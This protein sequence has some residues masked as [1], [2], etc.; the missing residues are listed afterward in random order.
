MAYADGFISFRS[1]PTSQAVFIHHLS[2]LAVQES[3]VVP[4]SVNL[5][6]RS[7]DTLCV[8]ASPSKVLNLMK[9]AEAL[10]RTNRFVAGSAVVAEYRRRLATAADREKELQAYLKQICD[11]VGEQSYDNLYDQ[12]KARTEQAAPEAKPPRDLT[13]VIGQVLEA[14]PAF[15][16][17][18]C[19]ERLKSLQEKVAYCPPESQGHL[20]AM[21]TQ[22]LQE[23]LG[24]PDCDWKQKV[25]R[26]VTGEKI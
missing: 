16:D 9:E 6:L 24:T 20:W 18:R 25:Q 1:S 10:E 19:M 4:G 7:G 12:V 22:I 3:D 15:G 11:L 23:E 26:I 5:T 17:E 13:V 2:I 8:E 14:L 21:I